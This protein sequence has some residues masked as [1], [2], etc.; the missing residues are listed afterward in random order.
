MLIFQ[1]QL[2]TCVRSALCCDAD[3]ICA[4][5][6]RYSAWNGNSK[7]TFRHDLSVS[8]TRVEK[9]GL[10]SCNLF[11]CQ[12]FNLTRFHSHRTADDVIILKK[13]VIMLMLNTLSYTC[14]WLWRQ[15]LVWGN[16]LWWLHWGTVGILQCSYKNYEYISLHRNL[17]KIEI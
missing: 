15:C 17:N 8:P 1:T 10:V 4:L 16:E 7:P 2:N 5:L 12:V 6:G 9:S 11:N 3:K 13:L 14:Y